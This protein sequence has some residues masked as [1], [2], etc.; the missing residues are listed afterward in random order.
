[1]LDTIHA[2]EWKRTRTHVQS[3]G[4]IAN[5]LERGLITPERAA[6]LLR[7]L[8]T[9]LGRDLDDLKAQQEYETAQAEL[10]GVRRGRWEA[11]LERGQ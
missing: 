8:Q 5:G 7:E 3:L 2:H 11:E 1:M 10:S 6:E 9:W 4:A